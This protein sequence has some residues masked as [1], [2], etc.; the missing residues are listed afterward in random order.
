MLTFAQQVND[1]DHDKPRSQIP[2]GCRR[3]A[4]QRP[5]GR[6]DPTH[7]HIP[8]TTRGPGS[9]PGMEEG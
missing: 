3:P 5:R 6:S 1:V 7:A 9:E 2:D 4:C 8:G